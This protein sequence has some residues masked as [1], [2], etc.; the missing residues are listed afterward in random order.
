MI[1]AGAT[2]ADVNKDRYNDL[3][4]QLLQKKLMILN[5]KNYQK[6]TFLN[7][8]GKSFKLVSDE[9]KLNINNFSTGA[10]FGDINSDGY[11]DLF[12]GNYFKDFAKSWSFK[13]IYN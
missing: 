12:V 10:V 13:W 6:S 9:F 4:T 5:T 8:G 11:P 1:T 7:T 3:F 2:T